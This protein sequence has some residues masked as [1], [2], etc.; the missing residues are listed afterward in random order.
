MNDT[1]GNDLQVGTRIIYSTGVRP[2]HGTAYVV[3][4]VKRLIPSTT[5]SPDKVVVEVTKTTYSLPL[6]KDPIVNAS[7]VVSLESL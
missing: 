7:N 6:S 4:R 2:A 1:F 5:T 3:G